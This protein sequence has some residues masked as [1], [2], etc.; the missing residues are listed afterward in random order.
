MVRVTTQLYLYILN[1]YSRL[2]DIPWV[3][4][5]RSLVEC[6]GWVLG[7]GALRCVFGGTTETRKRLNYAA[8]VAGQIEAFEFENH[9]VFT[10]CEDSTRRLRFHKQPITTGF[11]QSH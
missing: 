6:V 1:H 11:R 7:M 5:R 8:H 10:C 4:D 9:V 2:L 3:F